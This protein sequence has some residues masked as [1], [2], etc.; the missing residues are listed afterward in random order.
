MF[1]LRL[2]IVTFLLA[3][4]LSGPA[5]AQTAQEA[6]EKG[7]YDDVGFVRD[8][9]KQN[10]TCQCVGYHMRLYASERIL[11]KEMSSLKGKQLLKLK[12]AAAKSLIGCM[13]HFIGDLFTE[14]C[15]QA[16]FENDMTV[17]CSCMASMGQSS[18]ETHR[19]TWLDQIDSQKD[20]FKPDTIIGSPEV[21]R[22]IAEAMQVCQ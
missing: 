15:K 5:L 16:A 1:V 9:D 21:K 3:L 20:D 7:C 17:D 14:I 18:L 6:F 2:T 12:K 13:D 19:D 4:C 10:L 22:D 8:K 11:K